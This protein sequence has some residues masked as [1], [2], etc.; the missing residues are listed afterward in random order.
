MG[1]FSLQCD[2]IAAGIAARARAIAG[3]YSGVGRT[4]LGTPHP[5]R[6]SPIVVRYAGAL[7]VF[8][9]LRAG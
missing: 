4:A 5:W 2:R 1:T 8:G 9:T 7:A 3:A 6:A